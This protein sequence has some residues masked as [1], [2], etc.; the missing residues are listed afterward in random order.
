MRFRDAGIALA[1]RSIGACIDLAVVLCG[2]RLPA[3]LL[4]WAVWSLP[5]MATV[6]IVARSSEYGWLAAWVAVGLASAPLG[7]CLVAYASAVTFAEPAEIRR[8]TLQAIGSAWPI[9]LARLA[10]RV[11]QWPLLL[12][13]GLPGLVL[14]VSM[15]FLAES[16]VLKPFRRQQ[17]DHRMRDVVKQE[18]SDLISR[19]A[20]LAA[21]GLAL[22]FVLTITADAAAMLLFDVPLVLG[23]IAEATRNPW[24]SNDVETYL[25]GLGQ[26]LFHDPVSLTT[27]TGTALAAYTLCR[28]AWFL[29]YVDLRL[30][31]DCWDLEIA[32]AEEAE[33]WEAVR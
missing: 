9:L 17:H 22:W 7:L 11:V 16:R 33:R 5:A 25:T 30:R 15:A 29:A 23:R 2:Q 26:T 8:R 32:L 20:L 21:F 13:G 28:L 1:P 6:W 3:C 10:L 27:L 24:G 14:M 12:L 19:A 18:F 4:I 31:R